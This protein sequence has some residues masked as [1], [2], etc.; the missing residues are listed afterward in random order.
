MAVAEDHLRT[1]TEKIS[2]NCFKCQICKIAV[3]LASGEYSEKKVQA[4]IV[5]ESDG[6]VKEDSN[7]VEYYQDGIRPGLFKTLVGEG[8]EEFSSAR[9]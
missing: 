6:Q 3:G 9:Q 5:V 1:C 7:E 8:H 4:K 2:P